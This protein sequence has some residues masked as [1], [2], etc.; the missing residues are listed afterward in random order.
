VGDDFQG[1]SR[2]AEAVEAVMFDSPDASRRLA[3]LL[4]GSALLYGTAMQY[5]ARLYQHRRLTSHRLP[6]KVV[7]VGN[8]TIGGTGKTPMALYLAEMIKAAG[9]RAAVVSRGY[10]GQAEKQ[11]GVVSDGHDLRMDSDIAG[12][13]PYLMAQQLLPSGIPVIVGRDRVHSGWLAVKL[14][15]TEVLVLD[16]GFQHLRLQRDLNLVLLDARQPFGNGY[17]LPRGILREPLSALSRADACLLT[18]CPPEVVGLQPL[19]EAVAERHRPPEDGKRRV[20]PA[21]H[22]PYV[23][24]WIP[25]GHTDRQMGM[26]PLEDVLRQP[27]FVFSGI[28]R[29]DDF[30]AA[31]GQMGFDLRGRIAFDDHYRYT[32]ADIAAIE[33]RAVR[34]GAKIMVSTQKDWAKIDPTW[35]R[36]LPLL[37]VGVQIDLGVYAEAF[38]RF[39]TRKLGL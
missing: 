4:K 16:D 11:G 2:A 22:A 39:V 33:T 35:V 27:V 10:K 6:C 12:D 5:R 3:A 1:P 9:Y 37:V 21:A 14:F 36:R 18:R 38:Q 23:A 13:E 29:N 28:A 15:Q 26:P 7:S 19:T 17:L 25:G 34:R 31:L 32:R 30:Q 20:F 24:E 8:I